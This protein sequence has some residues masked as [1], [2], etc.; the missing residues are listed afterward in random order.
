M[1]KKN[2]SGIQIGNIF[3]FSF[4]LI[5]IVSELIFRNSFFVF[6][7]LMLFILIVLYWKTSLKK[8]TLFFIIFS[9]LLFSDLFFIYNTNIT[10]LYGSVLFI[11][12]ELVLAYYIIKLIKLK[13]FFPLLI[14]IIPFHLIFFCLFEVSNVVTNSNFYIIVFQYNL[15]SII[16]CITLSNYMISNTYKYKKLILF[17]LLF[18]TLNSIVFVQKYWITTINIMSYNVVTMILN[19]TVNYFFYKWVVDIEKQSLVIQNLNYD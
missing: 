15:V 1:I 7:P 13:D 8:N 2:S 3:Y 9:L 17:G 12:Y 6:K 10:F 16:G 19:A 14:A 4:L 18:V 11:V 5:N